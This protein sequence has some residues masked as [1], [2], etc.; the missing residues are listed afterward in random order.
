MAKKYTPLALL[1]GAMSLASGCSSAPPYDPQLSLTPD[2]YFGTLVASASGWP[3]KPDVNISDAKYVHGRAKVYRGIG[4]FTEAMNI[5][6][7]NS[8]G[9]IVSPSI[10]AERQAMYGCSIPNGQNYFYTLT[11]LNAQS[12]DLDFGYMELIPGSDI[13][14]WNTI[15]S[16][17][18][19]RF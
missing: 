19:L 16:A 10:K 9:S 5:Y 17:R 1:I 3:Y 8:G 6:C 4:Y 7:T 18:G 2:E 13:S 11:Q 14:L 15:T 12:P